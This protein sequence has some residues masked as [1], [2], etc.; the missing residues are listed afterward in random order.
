MILL[1]AAAS[2]ELLEKRDDRYRVPEALRPLLT[3]DGADTVLPMIHLRMN[4]FRSWGQLAWITRA[5]IPAP[6][7]ASIRGPEADRAAFVGF[8]VVANDMPRNADRGLL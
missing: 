1:D 8:V 6:K 5:G 7:A 4:M 3:R 2:L